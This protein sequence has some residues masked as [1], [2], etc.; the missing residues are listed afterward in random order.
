MGRVKH[1]KEKSLYSVLWG[2]QKSQ[3]GGHNQ[4]LQTQKNYEVE[5]EWL[6]KEGLG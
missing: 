4:N 6:T 1:A 3:L 5:A 2:T